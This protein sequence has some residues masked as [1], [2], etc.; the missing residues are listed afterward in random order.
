MDYLQWL[1]QSDP[2]VST[3]TQRYLLNQK[4]TDATEGWIGRLFALPLLQHRGGYRRRMPPTRLWGV[5]MAGSWSLYL[6]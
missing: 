1:L 2:A 5:A 3:M 4:T 6:R